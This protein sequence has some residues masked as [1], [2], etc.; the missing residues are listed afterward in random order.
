MTL[1]CTSWIRSGGELKTHGIESHY[2]IEPYP[3]SRVLNES[4]KVISR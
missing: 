4:S 2:L 1:F 3:Y